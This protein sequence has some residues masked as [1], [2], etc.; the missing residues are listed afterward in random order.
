MQVLVSTIY[1]IDGARAVDVAVYEND[2]L[3]SFET[4]LL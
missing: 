3:V 1:Y 2:E 4:L